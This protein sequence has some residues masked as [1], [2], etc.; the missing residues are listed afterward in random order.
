M[1]KEDNEKMSEYSSCGSGGGGGIQQGFIFAF[2]KYSGIRSN[3]SVI[4]HLVRYLLDSDIIHVAMI[5]AFYCKMHLETSPLSKRNFLWKIEEVHVAPTAFTAF[6]GIGVN[7]PETQSIL[8]KNY[9]YYFMPVYDPFKFQEGLHFL[10][11]LRGS[12]YNYLDLPFTL[13]PKK[14]KHLSYNNNYCFSSLLD[15][16]NNMTTLPSSL[17]WGDK[18]KKKRGSD[19]EEAS[20]SS[21]SSSSAAA[22]RQLQLRC[23]QQYYHSPSVP[24]MNTN[25]Q[26][27]NKTDEKNDINQHSMQ[28]HNK[29]IFC[30]QMG[31]LLCYVC[32]LLPYCDIDPARCSPYDLLQVI[33]SDE[34]CISCC[35]R[36]ITI[37]NDAAD[38]FH[39]F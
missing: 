12:N 33:S 31:L 18:P 29:R 22:Q 37:L 11:S 17:F 1:E 38:V 7:E 27:K 25:T 28:K 35:S 6:W 39:P 21:S 20:S 32:D 4:Q 23:E 26:L 24:L 2:F 16:E 9:D 14:Y 36:K 34:K 13:I 10:I 3:A 15:D 19:K 5:P 8:N 30:S